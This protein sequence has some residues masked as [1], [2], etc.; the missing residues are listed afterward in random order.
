MTLLF[1][2]IGDYELIEQI[3]EGGMGV[4]FK[5]RQRSLDRLVALKLI[6]ASALAQAGDI[7]RFQ[8]EA[9]VPARLRHPNIVAIYDVGEHQGQPF[10]SMELVPGCSLAEALR[11]GPFAA[12]RAAR[13]VHSVAIA[14]H[15]AHQHGVVHR[16]LKPSNIL[17]DVDGKPRVADFGLAKILHAGSELTLSGAILGSPQYMP[18]E[19]ARGNSSTTGVRSD[20]YSLGAILYELLTGWPPFRA[21]TPLETLQLVLEQDPIPPRALNPSLPRDLE[22]ICLKCL[23]KEPSGRYYDAQQLADELGRF[24]LGQPIHARPVS[25]VE[26]AWRWCRR[27]PVLTMLLAILAAAPAIIIPMLVATSMRVSSEHASDRA[28]LYAADIAQASHSLNESNY[29]LAWRSLDRYRPAALTSKQKFQTTADLRGYEWRWL[30]QHARGEPRA[31]FQAHNSWVQTMNYSPDGRFAASAS[32]DGTMAIWDAAL[33]KLLRRVRDPGC[34]NS[35]QSYTDQRYDLQSAFLNFS[36]SFSADS[37]TLLT[38]SGLGLTLWDV[39]SGECLQNFATNGFRAAVFSPTDPNLAL[40]VPHVLYSL[41]GLFDLAKGSFTAVFTNGRSDAVCFR[42]DGGQFARWDRISRCIYVQKIP[43]G[44]EVDSFATPEVKDRFY[45]ELMAF[46]PDGQTLAA[47]NIQ[48]CP[49][50]LFDVA[51]QRS[52]DPLVGHTARGCAL[53]VSRDGRLLASGG[54]DQTIRLWDLPAR[55]EV[56]Q[57]HGHRGPVY[58]LAFSPNG[59]RLASGGFDGTVRFWDL[60]PPL[61]PPAIS[62]VFG[63]FA[64]S[65]NARWLVTQNTNGEARLWELPERR[66]ISEWTTPLFQSAVFTTN[67]ELLLGSIGSSDGPPGMQKLSLAQILH[68]KFQIL[69]PTFFLGITSPCSIVALSAD[70]RTAVTGHRDGTVAFWEPSSG[71]LRLRVPPGVND[72]AEIVGIVFA[73]DGRTVATVSARPAFVKIWSLPKGNL[74]ATQFLGRE[75]RCALSPDG[76]QVATAGLGQA[77]KINLWEARMHLAPTQLH[78]HEDQLNALA[79]SQDGRT[80]A[81]AGDDGFLK[82]WHLASRRELATVESLGQGAFFRSLVFSP[83]GTWLGASDNEGILHLYHSPPLAELDAAADRERRNDE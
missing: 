24:E 52:A 65:P 43:S 58:S 6:R 71:G 54:Y 15:F 61:A 28:N 57:L 36:A 78:G 16:D 12:K 72:S 22:S 29:D 79:Y 60:E 31:T 35:P 63:L 64:F 25:P 9:A 11:E 66:L 70:G 53:A 50:A 77:F 19:Q 51:R 67:G 4:I 33:E 13:L 14:M 30:W 17:L 49:V 21:A 82:L 56:R 48:D 74:L 1:R 47:C 27:E 39:E 73:A 76:S 46:S 5:A 37:R 68:F 44:E 83:D 34:T 62:N 23:T 80:L 59:Q 55:H 26:R 75:T 69:N 41:L 2:E 20:V 32:A 18:P 8:T 10:Y 3:G 81:S 45:S 40:A 7:V 38:C 42:P